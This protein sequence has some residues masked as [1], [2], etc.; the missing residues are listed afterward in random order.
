[1]RARPK[2]LLVTH[3]G[4]PLRVRIVAS[5]REAIQALTDLQPGLVQWDA[6]TPCPQWTVHDLSGH[7]L[8]IVRY[9]HRLLDAAEAGQHFVGLPRGADLAD[10]NATDLLNVAGLSGPERIE[11]FLGAA[12]DHLLRVERADWDTILGDWAGLGPLTVG[13]HSGVAIGEWHI[14][15]WD[16]ARSLGGDHRPGD[17]SIVAEGNRAV[18]E[19]STDGDPWLAVLSAYQRNPDWAP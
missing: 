1:V 16:M 5:Y 7:L 18:R 4:S 12:Q 10:M 13:Q 17:A 9:W 8:S 14:H 15:A 2:V 19:V 11:R 3:L 6:P